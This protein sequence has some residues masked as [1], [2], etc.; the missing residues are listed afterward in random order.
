MD[1]KIKDHVIIVTGGSKGIGR[2]IVTTLALE[3]AIPVIAGRSGDVGK[4]LVEELKAS[5]AEACFVQTELSDVDQC[6]EVVRQTLEKYGHLH[7][8]VNNA[9]IN[10]GVG[11]ENGSPEEFLA[12][13][14]KNLHHYY[15]MAHFCLPALKETRGSIVN[16]S[17]KTAMTGQGGTSGYAASKGAQLAMTRE[18][19]VELLKYNIR[20][21]AI[22]PAE[23]MTP[24]YENWLRTFDNPEAK[25]E[26]I[27]ANI[28]LGQR[29]TTT[30]EIASMAVYLLSGQAS[31]I[32]GQFMHVDGGYVHLDRALAGSDK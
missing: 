1:L 4:D 7:G 26:D 25:L 6:R 27:T 31:H 13:V 11:L 21:N 2:G 8:L 18:W 23:V 16:I 14:D 20:V 29:M 5:G 22:L 9:G 12:S 19:A 3:G 17:S 10:D 15:Y 24:L 32:T 28:P 30:E